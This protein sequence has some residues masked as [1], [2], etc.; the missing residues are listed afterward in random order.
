MEDGRKRDTGCHF[1]IG[2][3]SFELFESDLFSWEFFWKTGFYFYEKTDLVCDACLK[4]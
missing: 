3:R 1:M 4:S 2:C